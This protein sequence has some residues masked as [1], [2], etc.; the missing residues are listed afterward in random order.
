MLVIR[1]LIRGFPLSTNFRLSCGVYVLT[2]T[3]AVDSDGAT[4]WVQRVQHCWLKILLVKK[5]LNLS[6][7]QALD[8]SQYIYISWIFS[9]HSFS[10]LCM[11][12]SKWGLH[13]TNC[14]VLTTVQVV[15]HW[16]QP[17]VTFVCQ[18]MTVWQFKQVIVHT[19]CMPNASP[20]LLP[21]Q[22]TQTYPVSPSMYLTASGNMASNIP[23]KYSS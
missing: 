23:T 15:L 10:Y 2:H 16:M 9:L 13:T 21:C 8:A 5:S 6:F 12:V 11:A 1:R 14:V 3:L 22:K 19:Q 20:H 4:H 18:S 7:R 17:A